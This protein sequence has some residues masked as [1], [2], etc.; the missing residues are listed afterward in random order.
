MAELTQQVGLEEE[1]KIFCLVDTAGVGAGTRE[2]PREPQEEK[3][4]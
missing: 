2:V 3:R 1:E 4:E